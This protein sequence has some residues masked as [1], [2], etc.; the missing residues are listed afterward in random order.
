MKFLYLLGLLGQTR[1]ADATTLETVGLVAKTGYE[2]YQ[3]YLRD[4]LTLEEVRDQLL[5]EITRSRREIMNH[6]DNLAAIE[7]RTCAT[8]SVGDFEDLE[9][10]GDYAVQ[11]A[12]EM[13]ECIVLLRNTI[14]AVQ[15]QSVADELGFALHMM[16]PMTLLAFEHTGLSTGYL[17]DQLAAAELTIDEAVAPACRR[18]RVCEPGS[19]L[20]ENSVICTAYNGDSGSNFAFG[21]LPPA[22]PAIRY[23]LRNTS[24][25]ISS[26]P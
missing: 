8:S 23:A 7:A 12:G 5:A 11:V 10:Y 14:A 19:D 15:D 24:A 17:V 4:E 22:A 16:G 21:S 25:P 1:N 13:Y 2:L 3:K 18:R 26:V 9:T 20:C 6:M